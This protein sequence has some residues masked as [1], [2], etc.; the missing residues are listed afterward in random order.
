MFAIITSALAILVVILTAWIL[1]RWIPA[2]MKDAFDATSMLWGGFFLLWITALGAFL[3][4][5]TLKA[6]AEWIGSR[7]PA[8]ARAACII[9]MLV[10]VGLIVMSIMKLLHKL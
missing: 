9:G 6:N 10:A 5:H 7:K 3:P 4:A 1:P 8:V 2:D